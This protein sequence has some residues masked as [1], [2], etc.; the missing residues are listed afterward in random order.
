MELN[1]ENLP[2]EILQEIFNYLTL[3]DIINFTS[4]DRRLSE[5]RPVDFINW[6]GGI[7]KCNFAIRQMNYESDNLTSSRYAIL[8]NNITNNTARSTNLITNGIIYEF[9]KHV[10]GNY[11]YTIP[12][13][14]DVDKLTV[15]NW[16]GRKMSFKRDQSLWDKET[17]ETGAMYHR[18][19][20]NCTAYLDRKLSVVEDDDHY[21]I[22]ITNY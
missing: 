10:P 16:S 7:N 19:T 11:Y 13:F 17:W 12:S 20:Y 6:S 8:D 22:T 3:K 18:M 21:T 9:V 15:H 2:N 1:T 5:L 4:A 14:R